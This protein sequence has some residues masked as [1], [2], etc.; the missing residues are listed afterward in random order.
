MIQKFT[1]KV[2]SQEKKK[3]KASP[4]GSQ[5]TT[6]VIIPI[7]NAG[8]HTFWYIAPVRAKMQLNLSPIPRILVDSAAFWCV[9]EQY[10]GMCDPGVILSIKA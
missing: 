1:I 6:L 7:T 10:T 8:G 5:F 9:R 2:F 3:K 4:A